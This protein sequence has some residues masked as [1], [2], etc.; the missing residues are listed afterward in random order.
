MSCDRLFHISAEK[1]DA[2]ASSAALF[3]MWIWEGTFCPSSP[4]TKCLVGCLTH[5]HMPRKTENMSKFCVEHETASLSVAEV[6]F[7]ED[8]CWRSVLFLK[9]P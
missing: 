3:F 6:L 1:Q 9:M 8:V 4:E 5:N 2:A 7:F